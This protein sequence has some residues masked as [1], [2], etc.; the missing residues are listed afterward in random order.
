[1]FGRCR[2]SGAWVGVVYNQ[3]ES[4]KS[5]G[6]LTIFSAAYFATIALSIAFRQTQDLHQTGSGMPRPYWISCWNLGITGKLFAD[7]GAGVFRIYDEGH[8]PGG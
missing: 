7:E 3:A 6:K 1:M 2:A 5:D 8:K 4:E